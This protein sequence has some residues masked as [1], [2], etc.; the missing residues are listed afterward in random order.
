[1]GVV[2]EAI[3]LASSS[4][5]GV[6]IVVLDVE[7]TMSSVCFDLHIFC[8]PVMGRVSLNHSSLC[9][10]AF[11]STSSLFL[12]HC[13]FLFCVLVMPRGLH[14]GCVYLESLGLALIVLA[15]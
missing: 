13:N 11:C 8:V 14:L 3:T 6:G 4:F 15:S 2:D 10:S 1:M 9:S 12:M 7:T 5:G